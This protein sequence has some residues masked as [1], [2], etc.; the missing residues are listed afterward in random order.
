MVKNPWTSGTGVQKT[1]PGFK[2]FRAE[3]TPLATLAEWTP[4]A[5]LADWTPLATL[6]SILSED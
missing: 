3:W 1:S 2:G 5:I 6:V 4:L